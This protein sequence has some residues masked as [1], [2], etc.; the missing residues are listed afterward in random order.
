MTAKEKARRA[1]ASVALDGVLKYIKKSP[2]ENFVKMLN[3]VERFADG[4]FPE[5]NFDAF[6]KAATD[7]N[8][9]W[10]SFAMGLINDLDP[11]ALKKMLL[12]I[13]LGAAIDGTKKV[14]E[15]REK[16]KCNIPFIIL[17]DPTS[18]C[19]LN[20]KGCWSAQ[21]GNKY[22]L[23]LDDMRSI[24]RQGT[25]LGT[26]FYMFTGGEPLIRKNDILTLCEENPDCGFLAYTNASFV[27]E[28]F[29]EDMKRAGNL[30]LALSVEGTEHTNDARR[31]E[32]SYERSM[33]AMELLR[34]N[35]LFFGLSVCYTAQNVDAVTSDE[36]LDKMIANGA[37]YALYFNYMPVGKDAVESLIPSPE[38]R[39][40]MYGWLRKMRN[41]ETGKP[42]FIMDFQDDGEYVGGCIAGGRNYFHINSAGDME[43][44]VFI[45]YAD[46]NIHTDTILEALQKPLFQAYWHNQPFN[47]N[48]LRPCPLLENPQ[49]LRKIIAETGAKSTN[50]EAPEDVETLCSRCDRFAKAWQPVADEL[51]A[52]RTHPNPKTQYYRDMKTDK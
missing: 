35:G 11:D 27:D 45:H 34:K 13:G 6:R 4:S 49:C 51:W 44:C 20:C 31:G 12:A 28:K 23:S 5:K 19:N 14:R 43:P 40:F 47:E 1:A 46:S 32:G 37:K 50:L 26:H 38:Q 7:K 24:V 41:G 18:A 48:H 8:N 30:T 21:Y 2:E 10:H 29:C 36:F 22:N 42:I 25:E 9:V 17:L 33:K 39:S 15:N 3:L 16:Y 52:S